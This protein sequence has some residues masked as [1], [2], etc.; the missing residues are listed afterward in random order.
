MKQLDTQGEPEGAVKM[1][2][3]DPVFQETGNALARLRACQDTLNT[4]PSM[5]PTWAVFFY[6]RMG[7]LE[8]QSHAYE[9]QGGVIQGNKKKN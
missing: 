5:N 9:A 1:A 8:P 2:T 7:C 4:Y 3:P 6:P